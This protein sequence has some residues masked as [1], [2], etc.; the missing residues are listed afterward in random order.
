MRSMTRRKF[1][2]IA[3]SATA[4]ASIPAAARILMAQTPPAAA[5]Y[6]GPTPNSQFYITSYGSTP[7][8]DASAWALKLH[9][10]VNQPL[11]LSYKG[12][13]ELPPIKELL[14]YECISNTPDGSAISSAVF[15]GTRLK[16]L[17]ERAGVRPK[18][19][20]AAMRAADGYY[21]GVPIDEIMSGDTFLLYK[22]N[23]V[24]LPPVHGYPVRIF[25]PGKYGMKQPKWIT[26]IQFVDQ[27]FT[28][29]WEARGWS[30]EAWRKV[31]SGFFYPQAE[32]GVFSFFSQTP[33]AKVS[34]APFDIWGWAFAGKSGIK[35]VQISTD[36]GSRWHDATLVENTSPNTWTVWKYNFAPPKPASYALRVRATDGNGA[37]QPPE[38][39][40]SGS[41]MDGQA[42]MTLEVS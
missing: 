13:K 6:G 30:N 21:T 41:G 31:N 37:A 38:S 3:A 32:G 25:I 22:M 28:G 24:P 36:G 14:T 35:R 1:L 29:Y 17:L 34:G 9:G 7:R 5:K 18:A 26:D 8:L 11:E 39:A 23:G 10:L 33:A 20:Y 2:S 42:Q 4:A 16:P 27:K 15:T 19:V 40:Q 12:V